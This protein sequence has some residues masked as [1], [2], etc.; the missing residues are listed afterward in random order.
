MNITSILKKIISIIISAI[1]FYV[2]IS[3]L[4]TATIEQGILF[5]LLLTFGFIMVITGIITILTFIREM[6]RIKIPERLRNYLK[7][8][9]GAPFVIAFMIL[10]IVAAVYLSLGIETT[11]N[12]IATY[13]YYSLVIGVFLQLISYIRYERKENKESTKLT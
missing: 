10:L 13:A 1:L 9:W 3:A 2:G 6:L 5:P 7:E 12:D 4:Y 11:A 8:N